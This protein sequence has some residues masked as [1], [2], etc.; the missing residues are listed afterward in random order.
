MSERV[1]QA[2][3]GSRVASLQLAF[4]NLR[5]QLL[6]DFLYSRSYKFPSNTS[7]SVSINHQRRCLCIKAEQ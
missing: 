5:M 7:G 2:L 6:T 3:L 4:I 1:D